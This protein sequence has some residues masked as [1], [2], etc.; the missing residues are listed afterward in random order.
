MQ[1]TVQKLEKTLT[2]IQAY[3]A[4]TNYVT[5]PK[6]GLELADRYDNL[7]KELNPNGYSQEWI[8]YCERHGH[9]RA[10]NGLDFFC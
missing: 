9:D 2:S 10:H 5:I 1:T 6:R 4:R 8:D 7:T 3:I